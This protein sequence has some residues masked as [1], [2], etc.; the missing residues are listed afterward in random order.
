MYQEKINRA[1]DAAFRAELAQQGCTAQQGCADAAEYPEQPDDIQTVTSD[2]DCLLR[3]LYEI[4]D[5]TLRIRERLS[6]AVPESK[7]CK[8]LKPD[9]I[10]Y[11][12]RQAGALASSIIR[13]LDAVKKRL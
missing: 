6:G 10:E 12:V 4:S 11:R 9:S 3:T 5:C 8:D 13:D 1:V 2:L 7:D